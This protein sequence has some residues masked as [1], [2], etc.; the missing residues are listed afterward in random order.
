MAGQRTPTLI[1]FSSNRVSLTTFIPKTPICNILFKSCFQVHI[2]I[3]KSHTFY[4]FFTL[5]Q[6]QLASSDAVLSFLSI[7]HLSF[8]LESCFLKTHS[9]SK[10][11][12]QH[13]R[14]RPGPGPESEGQSFHVGDIGDSDEVYIGE[15]LTDD[16]D[17]Y[18][19]LTN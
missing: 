18:R 10:P 16:D 13:R 7:A 8:L 6:R 14:P 4:S 9:S 12:S 1:F 2:F 11:Q 3:I 19:C 17:D 5:I 15:R